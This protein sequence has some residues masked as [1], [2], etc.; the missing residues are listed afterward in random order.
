VRL[1]GGE[2]QRIALARALLRKPAL[3]L[4]DEA[5]SSLD[6]VN[7]KRIQ[8]AIAGLHGKLTLVV[9]AHRL[10]TIREADAIVVLDEGRV[11]EQGDWNTLAACDG[12]H[13]RSMLRSVSD[14]PRTAVRPLPAVG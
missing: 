8:D 13:F 2:R 12:G 7:E 3:L 6:S 14:I 9:I 10:T 5:T 1:S 4:L 11:V